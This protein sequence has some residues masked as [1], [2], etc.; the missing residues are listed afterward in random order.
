MHHATLPLEEVERYTDEML[1]KRLIA[2]DEGRRMFSI[3][4]AGWSYL[5]LLDELRGYV[6][7]IDCRVWKRSLHFDGA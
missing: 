2:W 5:S 4:T 3:L 6:G 1:A 7:D